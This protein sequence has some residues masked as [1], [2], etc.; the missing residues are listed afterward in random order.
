[1][2]TTEPIRAANDSD[3]DLIATL[4]AELRMEEQGTTMDRAGVASVVRSAIA[5]ATTSV[6]VAGKGG[7]VRGFIVVH[8]LPFPMLGGLCCEPSRMPP[9]DWSANRGTRILAV[10]ASFRRRS[11]V[12]DHALPR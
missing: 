6:L 8:W 5:S 11:W 10:T 3:S 7:G 4:I 12:A 2:G 1:M 9:P